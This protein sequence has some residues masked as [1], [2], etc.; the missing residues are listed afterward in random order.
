MAG[1]DAS[2]PVD[3]AEAAGLA[4]SSAV[5]PRMRS[6]IS[7]MSACEGVEGIASGAAAGL[8]GVV[9]GGAAAAGMAGAG[10]PDFPE[11]VGGVCDAVKAGSPPAAGGKSLPLAG[12]SAP[13]GPCGLRP[14]DLRPERSCGRSGLPVSVARAGSADASRSAGRG[15]QWDF[16]SVTAN[17]S[18][19]LARVAPGEG[20]TVVGTPTGKSAAA[21]VVVISMQEEDA[22]PVPAG[23]THA[24]RTLN[25]RT[26]DSTCCRASG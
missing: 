19:A 5:V 20:D 14:P 23:S 4:E 7:N 3:D 25:P 9:L 1:L 11:P 10:A 13:P 26:L 6:C 15:A 2:G 12:R 21:A 17:F 16:W 8:A 18:G 24:S 22:W